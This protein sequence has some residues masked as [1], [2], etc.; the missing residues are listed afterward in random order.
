MNVL[1]IQENLW[2]IT[3]VFSSVKMCWSAFS[4]KRSLS[5]C[6]PCEASVLVCSSIHLLVYICFPSL[7]FCVLFECINHSLLHVSFHGLITLL[8]Q[9]RLILWS[10]RGGNCEWE[11]TSHGSKCSVNSLFIY[12]SA[13]CLPVHSELAVCWT[14]TWTGRKQL[15]VCCK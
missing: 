15:L 8:C 7:F 5:L 6:E 4:N 12:N 11:L 10:R 3:Q 9:V 14:K 1:N 2:N 13:L